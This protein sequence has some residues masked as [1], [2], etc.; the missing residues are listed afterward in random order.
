MTARPPTLGRQAPN[1]GFDL[2][3][4]LADT[5][6]A[7]AVA[8]AGVNH[9]FGLGIDIAEFTRNTGLPMRE[10]LAPW[11][12]E[13]RADELIARFRAIFLTDGLKQLRPLPGAQ[14]ALE[15][16]R[17]RGGRAVIITSR[18]PQVARAMTECCGLRADTVI[19]GLAGAEKAAAMTSEGVG[20][21]V[22]DHVLDMQGAKLAGCL[23]VGVLTGYQKES[24]L[25][26]AGADVV[27]PDLTRSDPVLA[28][29]CVR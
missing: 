12:P 2:D 24:D 19:G 1:V 6:Q 9:E 11:I 21:Y 29:A 4:T 25:L 27:L 14:A 13:G 16:C 10:Q 8:A 5:R 28:A 23:A 17:S 22:G 26:A 20:V 3:L 7:T 18:L 15:A